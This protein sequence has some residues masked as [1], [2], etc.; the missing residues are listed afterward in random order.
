M[1]KRPPTPSSLRVLVI[2]RHDASRIG[3][4]LMLRHTPAVAGC[5][6]ASVDE[7]AVALARTHTPGVA[8]IDISERGPFTGS[9][10]AALREAAPGIR[11]VLTSRCATSAA[12]AVRAVGASAFIP[13][14]ADAR[15]TVETVLAAAHRAEPQRARSQPESQLT[16]REREVLALLAS[17][18]TNR[19]IAAEL[20][21]GAEAV[22]K[23]ASA[24]YR[25]LGVRNRTEAAHRAGEALAPRS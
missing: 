2:D 1:G 11:L 18:A 13:A 9:L 15:T 3:L 21:L 22:K 20:H 5:V 16:D 6:A 7:D 23:H 17:G 4:T 12:A 10:A 19:E 14:G 24:I 25:K 8:V